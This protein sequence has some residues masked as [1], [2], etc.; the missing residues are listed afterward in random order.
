[1]NGKEN[2]MEWENPGTALITGAS[3]GIGAEF[4]RKLAS[5]GFSLVLVARR[6]NKL[7]DLSKELQ[8]KY[9]VNT[10]VF[11]A[12]LSN[13]DDNEKI[14]TKIQKSDNLDVLINNAGY[15]ILSPFL[16]TELKLHIEMVNVHFTST[17]MFCHAALPTMINRKRGAI[18]NTSSM[19]AIYRTPGNV[20]YTTTKAAV[21]AY[22]EQ[23]K[24]TI[25]D[26]GVYIQSLCPGFVHTEIHDTETM[27]GWWEAGGNLLTEEYWMNTEEV[28]S[29]SLEAVKTGEVIFIPGEF[30]KKSAKSARKK[31][32]ENYLNAKIM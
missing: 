3:S 19:A 22:T 27:Q 30:N 25:K 4:A 8:E 1:M 20:M 7:D 10:E 12:D 6:K 2:F 26:T 13:I 29:L 17:V 15:G 23:L 24:E 14:V 28:V 16:Q 21:T 31:S 9:S 18:I 11:V 32:L 5:Q